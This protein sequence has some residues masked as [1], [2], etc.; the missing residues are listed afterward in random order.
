M[1]CLLGP[2]GMSCLL[3]PLGMSSLSPVCNAPV[4]TVAVEVEIEH[5]TR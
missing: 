1:S 2:L 4:K 5:A 3:G